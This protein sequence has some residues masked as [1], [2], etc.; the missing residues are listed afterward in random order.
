MTG[1]V[2]AV[3]LLKGFARHP[4]GLLVVGVCSFLRDTELAGLSSARAFPRTFR[5]LAR[6]MASLLAFIC[7]YFGAEAFLGVRV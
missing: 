3:E 4:I 5:E 6:A 2:T 7:I 1:P